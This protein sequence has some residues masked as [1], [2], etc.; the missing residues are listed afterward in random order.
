MCNQVPHALQHDPREPY[1]ALLVQPKDDA[2]ALLRLAFRVWDGRLAVGDV[3][4]PG[5][6]A[7]PGVAERRWRHAHKTDL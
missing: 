6:V 2:V 3:A 7:A 4:A 1:Q 5:G